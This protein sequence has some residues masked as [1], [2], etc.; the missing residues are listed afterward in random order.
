[1]QLH[2]LAQLE[3]MSGHIRRR[4]A[5]RPQRGAA[6]E[7]GDFGQQNDAIRGG[8]ELGCVFV[9]LH[10]HGPQPIGEGEPRALRAAEIGPSGASLCRSA[11]CRGERR[12]GSG[13]RRRRR[14]GR[15][16]DVHGR[17]RRRAAGRRRRKRRQR[18]RGESR[19]VI[20]SS[21]GECACS[22]LLRDIT[23]IGGHCSRR[24][25]GRAGNGGV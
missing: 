2:D 11:S 9:F 19:S 3:Q 20:R 17:Q 24:R 14:R 7:G 13:E 25:R 1:M 18:I 5:A 8:K 15:G 23:E 21:G 16:D 22:F 12:D 4:A 6:E 10:P